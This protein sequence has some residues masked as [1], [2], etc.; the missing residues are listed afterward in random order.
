MIDLIGGRAGNVCV[1]EYLKTG[2]VCRAGRECPVRY[3]GA[4]MI[5]NIWIIPMERQSPLVFIVKVVM[6]CGHRQSF[7]TETPLALLQAQLPWD[8]EQGEG[9]IWL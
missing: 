6:M 5:P 3:M 7:E 4:E 9:V 8:I 1:P 2:C